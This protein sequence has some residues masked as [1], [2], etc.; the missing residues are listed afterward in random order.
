MDTGYMPPNRH[1]LARVLVSA[2]SD[3]AHTTGTSRA[4]ATTWR[5]WSEWRESRSRPALLAAEDDHFA[6][7]ASF[8][9]FQFISS[10]GLAAST[11]LSRESMI[12]HFHTKCAV[13]YHPNATQWRLFRRG[14]KKSLGG[15]IAKQPV[16]IQLLLNCQHRLSS[17]RAHQA[18]WGVC[19]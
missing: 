1:Q 15:S 4:Y 7:V 3:M 8:L 5:N 12:R 13:E 9:T 11:M 6:E 18:L 16:S 2:F 17:S 14:L 10:G 19:A